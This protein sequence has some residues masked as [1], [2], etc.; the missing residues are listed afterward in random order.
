M[1]AAPSDEMMRLARTAAAVGRSAAGRK[2][3]WPS[4]WLFTDPDRTP[5]RLA[6]AAGLPAGAGV[7]LRTFGRPDVEALAPAL[8]G[9]TCL[10]SLRLTYNHVQGAG[11]RA[12]APG[13]RGLRALDL[14][15]N[16]LKGLAALAAAA[17]PPARRMCA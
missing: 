8:R 3:G 2:P 7:V 1:A 11:L 16:N 10:T 12:L 14:E 5:D 15:L 17:L 9:L 4:L 13:L 6:A